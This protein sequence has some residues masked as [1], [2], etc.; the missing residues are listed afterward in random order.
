[1]EARVRKKVGEEVRAVALASKSDEVPDG[2]ETRDMVSK[3]GRGRFGLIAQPQG[4]ATVHME[5]VPGRK[6]S[7]REEEGPI[8][9][10]ASVSSNIHASPQRVYRL[11]DG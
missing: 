4:V 7:S 2:V 8:T 6:L 1:M 3:S 11:S 9:R 5:N 10:K